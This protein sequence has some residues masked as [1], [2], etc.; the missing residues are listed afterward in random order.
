MLKI[1]CLW[2]MLSISVTVFAQIEADG[3]L[4]T[5]ISEAPVF[6]DGSDDLKAFI[7]ENTNYPLSALKDSVE[8]RAIVTFMIDTLGNTFDHRIVRSV[9]GD[10][11]EEALRVARLIKFDK[12]AKQKDRPISIRYVVSVDFYLKNSM[13][14]GKNL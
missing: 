8:G 2:M 9:R 12:P 14:M 11:D 1:G 13:D 5:V 4:I 6:R 3:Q 7:I 10:M